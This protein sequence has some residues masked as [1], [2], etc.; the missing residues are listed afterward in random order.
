MY[1]IRTS[2]ERVKKQLYEAM[3]R[4]TLSHAYVFEGLPGTG[5]REMARALAMRLHCENVPPL[6][7]ACGQCIACRQ[8][9]HDNH[10]AL[11]AV[12]PDGASIK[13]DQIRELKRRYTFRAETKRSFV[14]V[15]EEAERFTPQA[16]HAL[17]KFLEEPLEEV[18][19]ILIT[20]SGASLLPTIRSRVQRYTFFP[21]SP[22]EIESMLCAHVPDAPMHEV[23]IVAHTVSHVGI[24]QQQLTQ[25]WFATIVTTVLQLTQII[26]QSYFLAVDLA[27]KQLFGQPAEEHLDVFFD[28]FALWCK[29]MVLLQHHPDAQLITL[30][31]ASSRYR[32]LAVAKSTAHWVRVMEEAMN[33]KRK[34]R[35]N[36]NAQ[37]VLEKFLSICR[38]GVAEEGRGG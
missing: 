4:G 20:E 21:P 38:G 29:D 5:R 36:A 11:H 31:E 30:P 35:T 32:S 15:I 19:A 10:P 23:R 18:I 7:D 16:S 13:I 33:A 24:A 17:L 25:P 27:Q 34:L 3:D 37:L 28:V 2:F 1:A 26:D 9:V 14:Y 8:M 22:R 12:K 6:S